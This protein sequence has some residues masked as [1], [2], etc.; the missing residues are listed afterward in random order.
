M[1]KNNNEDDDDKI[2]R[3]KFKKSSYSEDS[4][5]NDDARFRVKY[6][7]SQQPKVKPEVLPDVDDE[8]YTFGFQP[9]FHSLHPNIHIPGEKKYKIPIRA[10][11]QPIIKKSFRPLEVKIKIPIKSEESLSFDDMESEFD[12][13][14][15][16]DRKKQEF[17]EKSEEL[18][19]KGTDEIQKT[20]S[21]VTNKQTKEEQESEDFKD[22]RTFLSTG[23]E[24][25]LIEEFYN[26]IIRVNNVKARSD[27]SMEG[28]IFKIIAEKA[29]EKG[30]KG[31]YK[32]EITNA[33]SQYGHLSNI[34]LEKY[35]FLFKHSG[36]FE[37]AER[38]K[39]LEAIN[40][41]RITKKL[42]PE[43]TFHQ[44]LL[45][46]YRLLRS[47]QEAYFKEHK[48]YLNLN[49]LGTGVIGK[50][51]YN[52]R[53]HLTQ[54]KDVNNFSPSTI[55]KIEC[56]AKKNLKI[57]LKDVQNEISN[58]RQ[59]NDDNSVYNIKD[60]PLKEIA[61]AILVL[62]S[63]VNDITININELD[64]L[65]KSISLETFGSRFFGNRFKK[66]WI[67]HGW[68]VNDD[69][70]NLLKVFIIKEFGYKAPKN[71]QQLIKYVDNYIASPRKQFL[72]SSLRFLNLKPYQ[73]KILIIIT[74]G[75]DPLY[76]DFFSSVEVASSK[77]ENKICRAHLDED[78]NFEFI[79]D[80]FSDGEDYNYRFKLAPLRFKASHNDLHERNF[81]Q[82]IG[83]SIVEAR[84]RHL[85]ELDKKAFDKELTIQDYYKIFKREFKEK[86]D[87]IFQYSKDV[88]IWNEFE[89]G[90]IRGLTDRCIEEFVR[91]WIQ[92]KKLSE[93]SWYGNYYKEFY[94]KKYIPFLNNL[95]T[96][97][98]EKLEKG[99]KSPFYE[100][101]LNEYLPNEIFPQIRLYECG[102][103]K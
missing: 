23:T 8:I 45:D 60:T 32:K 93:K 99:R 16:K 39:L 64:N 24:R 100:W 55:F 50:G 69:T 37:K 97:L 20:Q 83:N 102:L 96:Y 18:I 21:Y 78:P 70:M 25:V 95:R 40:S 33:L 65:L 19:N 51:T 46:E 62:Y 4:S 48:K 14:Y 75:M 44:D 7:A 79:F 29:S 94:N 13:D 11:P 26:V 72:R 77:I 9:P 89:N 3:V 57:Y 22:D 30:Y 17:E 61:Y 81:P 41:Y 58:W 36:I 34:F 87:F 10:T 90:E 47:I 85:Y 1:S 49:R 31:F 12:D 63:K 52:F 88:N 6:K 5:N 68:K 82:G 73:I 2:Y 67:S 98:K 15:I 91:R 66:E 27:I 80:I 76:C 42:L 54:K 53:Q 101:F 74:K 92:S 56:W 84:M 59:C 28:I 38:N 71:T 35:E 86:I 103:F 43:N